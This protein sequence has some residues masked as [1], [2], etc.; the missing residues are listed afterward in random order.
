M[1]TKREMR[2]L[3]KKMNKWLETPEGQ[4]ALADLEKRS[5]ETRKLIEDQSRVD[6]RTLREPMT[7]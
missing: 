2:R 7:F 5:E 3:R 6:Y 4:K 1:P